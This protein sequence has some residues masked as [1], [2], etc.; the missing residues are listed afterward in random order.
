MRALLAREG[1]VALVI[2]RRD[3]F[4]WATSGGDG[5]L[6]WTD[7]YAAGYLVVTPDRKFLVG[8]Q[9]DNARLAE[10]ECA[11]QGYEPVA[12]RW[13]E[14]DPAEAARRCAGPGKVLA[15]CSVPDTTTAAS[16]LRSLHYPLTAFEVWRLR[17]VC[18]RTERIVRDVADSLE[19]GQT[20]R[21]VQS[22]LAERFLAEGF[23]IDALMVGFD[24]RV[25]RY[26]HPM[27]R[28]N[29]LD[30]YAFVHVCVSRWGLHGILTRL[31]H[32][33][34]PPEDLQ[35]RF[36]AA[37]AIEAWTI[38]QTR[39]GTAYQ[40]IFDGQVHLYEALGYGDEWR[41]HFQ[42]GLTGYIVNEAAH[43]T[44]PHDLIPDGCP[45][46]WYITVTGAKKE[47]TTLATD[48]GG[49]VLSLGGA[50]PVERF[51]EP[52]HEQELADMLVR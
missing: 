8:Y 1:A 9:M 20:E 40:A 22:T 39:P 41:N 31:V 35:R 45:F 21:M 4:A 5:S 43:A 10:E 19:P 13:Y 30:R 23:T 24:R 28:D 50:W 44:R 42:G 33:G 27:P 2:G 25:Y 32:F 48:R 15:D 51:G 12:L 16:L 52:G 49:V 29:R 46:N 11:S 17:Y 36:A 18:Q 37:S 26:R 34:T 38:D 7:A 47:E 6:L 3:D 14:G